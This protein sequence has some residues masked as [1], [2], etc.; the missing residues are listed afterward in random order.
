MSH[1]LSLFFFPFL[2]LQVFV[3]VSVLCIHL[4]ELARQQIN[5]IEA[6]EIR[7]E[8]AEALEFLNTS[9]PR[10]TKLPTPTA[11]NDIIDALLKTETQMTTSKETRGNGIEVPNGKGKGKAVERNLNLN[12]NGTGNG[13]GQ[14][15]QNEINQNALEQILSPD[16]PL[17]V[18]INSLLDPNT[19][20][21]DLSP[22]NFFDVLDGFM[23]MPPSASG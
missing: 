21:S 23:P 6:E 18:Y 3:S 15:S 4:I 13:N 17:N 2:F 14:S 5:S 16:D 9:G 1:F 8:I 20:D 7:Q 22:P 11:S 12:G 10:G 19:S